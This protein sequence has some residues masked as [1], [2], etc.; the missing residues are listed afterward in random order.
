MFHICFR[1]VNQLHY[2]KK[3]TCSLVMLYVTRNFFSSFWGSLILGWF[4]RWLSVRFDLFFSCIWTLRGSTKLTYQVQQWN[5]LSPCQKLRKPQYVVWFR[6]KHSTPKP[7]SPAPGVYFGYW[8][9]CPFQP[10]S[11]GACACPAGNPAPR[12]PHA[13]L[14][15]PAAATALSQLPTKRWFATS[16]T[17]LTATG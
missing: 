1:R 10:G 13:P 16:G 9:V 17:P 12:S 4:F 8:C 14:A 7:Q 5:S 2:Q 15:A 3:L 11:A 6:K